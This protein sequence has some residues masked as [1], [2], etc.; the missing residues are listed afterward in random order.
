MKASD[1]VS[2][3]S[4]SLSFL[5]S[6]CEAWICLPPN[7]RGSCYVITTEKAHG[8]KPT[9]DVEWDNT[10]LIKNSWLQTQNCDLGLCKLLLPIIFHSAL[11]WC[12]FTSKHQPKAHIYKHTPPSPSLSILW[13]FHW[14]R[15]VQTEPSPHHHMWQTDTPTAWNALCGL[16]LLWLWLEFVKCKQLALINAL[17]NAHLSSL[18]ILLLLCHS[19]SKSHTTQFI[20]KGTFDVFGRNHKAHCLSH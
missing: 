15:W 11:Y 2:S 3:I 19:P 6:S 20:S 10:C 8:W 9:V 4:F 13:I 16:W 12:F 18:D 17:M 14:N 1:S 7:T 5:K